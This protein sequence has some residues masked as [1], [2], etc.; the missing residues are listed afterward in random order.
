VP[1]TVKWSAVIFL[2]MMLFGPRAHAQS[3]GGVFNA[4]SCLQ[5]DVNAVINGPLHVAVNGDT[6][7]IPA[8]NCTWTA[9]ITVPSGIGITIIGAG[10]P[11]SNPADYTPSSTCQQ[12]AITLT[13]NFTMFSA[14]PAYP[15]APT[16]RISCMQVTWSSGSTV[17]AQILGSCTTSGCPSIREDNLTFT[18]WIHR[19]E[20]YGYAIE[21]TGDV[22][23]VIDHNMIGDGTGTGYLQ[24]DQVNNASFFCVYNVN[25]CAWGDNSWNQPEDYGSANFLYMENNTFNNASCCEDEAHPGVIQNEGGGRVVVRFNKFINEDA[26]NGIATWHGTESSGRSRSIRAYEIYANSYSS[27]SNVAADSVALLRGGTGLAWANSV[28]VGSGSW[29]NNLLALRTYRAFEKIGGWGPC[30]GTGTWDQNDGVVYYSGTIASVSGSAGGYTITVS[31]NPNWTTNQWIPTGAPYSIHD[32][33]QNTGAEINS[34]GANTLY[35]LEGGWTTGV[36]AWVPAA[37]DSIEITR[38]TYCIDQAGGRGAGILY[39]GDPASPASAPNEVLSPIYSWANDLGSSSV[40]NDV[41]TNTMRTIR[42]RDFYEENKNQGAQ[43]S[44]TSPFDGSTTV[45]M[46]HGTLANR[47][48]TCTTGVGYWATDQGN[49]NHSSNTYSDGAG[50]SFSQGELYLCTATNTW[51]MSYE[52]Y[53]Y[54][55][56]LIAGGGTG[57][58]G[59]APAAP[60]GLVASVQ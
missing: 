59:N 19:A 44:P 14:T 21:G 26:L 8:G 28:T 25:T 56:P 10:T 30:D 49:W 52:P 33:T 32:V 37:G 39:S 16:F 60:S 5:A 47:P 27:T 36:G 2:L 7:Q 40:P 58:S 43:T 9:G 13:G 55:H 48:S 57:G 18:N 35:T 50:N 4:A 23:G 24:L 3:L 38:A 15:T 51:T 31:G 41:S 45:G 34:N 20:I 11:D 1:R 46:G 54:P 53:T 42:N 12:T 6:I 22:F 29:L 17:F